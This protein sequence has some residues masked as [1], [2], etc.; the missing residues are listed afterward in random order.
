MSFA[1]LAIVIN[2]GIQVITRELLVFL[3]PTFALSSLEIGPFEFEFWFLGGL[4][5][6]TLAGF[7]FKFLVDKF[8]VFEEKMES[9]E[10]TSRQASLYLG[11]AIITTI[12]FWGFEF[13][14][15]ILF[16]GDWYLIGGIIGLAIGYTVKF[17]LD[18][19]YVFS[20]T[21]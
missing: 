3:L 11:F 14:F 16:S 15:K 9:F 19:K 21:A 13:G 17:L 10:A 6:G 7:I 4:G 18:R 12:I 2:S 8:I 1:V 5:M 20:Q